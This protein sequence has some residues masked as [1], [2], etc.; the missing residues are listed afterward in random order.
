M[1]G[2]TR[3]RQACALTIAL[4]AACSDGRSNTGPDPQLSKQNP[5]YGAALIGY[6]SSANGGTDGEESEALGQSAAPGSNGGGGGDSASWGDASAAPEPEIMEP[7]PATC[8]PP[9]EQLADAGVPE[10][11]ETDDDAGVA[12]PKQLD[13]GTAQTALENPYFDTTVEPTS[14][15]ALDVDGASYSLTRAGLRAGQRPDPASVRL[16][17]FLNYFHLHY[18][19]PEGDQ[20]LALYAEL[21][22]CPWNP[23]HKLLMLGVQGQEVD[24]QDAPPANLVFL[25][26]VSGSMSASNK[27]PLVKKGFRMLTQLLRPQDRVSIVTYAGVERVVLEGVA[28]N[29]RERIHAALDSLSAGGSTNGAGGIQRA[30]ELA[31]EHFIKGGQN[32]VLLATDGDFNVGISDVTELGELIAKKR[33]TGVFLSVF[34]FGDAWNG[35]NFN[36]PAGE[37]LSNKG[38][39]IY[40]YVDSE[41]EARRAFLHSASG[42]LITVAKDVKIQVELNPQHFSA[43]RLLGYENR[44]LANEDFDN[45]A[46][47][48]GEL[49]ASLS[50]TALYELIPADVKEALPQPIEGT[51]PEVV[52]ASP[53]DGSTPT[54]A[55][56]ASVD[57]RPRGEQRV[58]V[59]VRYKG[60]EGGES[61][62]LSRVY[63]PE[64]LR[65]EPSL[66]WVFASVLA[67]LAA[68]LRNSQ[69][70]PQ[71]GTETLRT[72]LEPVLAIDGEG[73]VQE[74]IELLQSMP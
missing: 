73:A 69:Y 14:T 37:E 33:D 2:K 59:R 74:V 6:K 11:C 34:G 20:P 64:I 29:D 18:Q 44:L 58:A 16:E 53:S 61:E 41:E 1:I 48:G 24:V 36:D 28:G 38:D 46:V 23:S 52:S 12:M 7:D 56:S 54:L 68:N 72:R 8:Q 62:Q 50:M 45:D 25:L 13:T 26:D 39:G 27:L 49:G 3:W 35:G 9:S 5:N 4:S 32:R 47:D 40:F 66:K 71:R 19:Q 10:G 17:E 51:V 30:Y 21:G 67:E 70:Q 60:P 15:F 65:S 42:A 63:G 22:E 55:S 31:Q 57:E 43:Y